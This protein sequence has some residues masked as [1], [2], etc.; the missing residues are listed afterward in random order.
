MS[1]FKADSKTVAQSY[2]NRGYLLHE[3][4]EIFPPR[5]NMVVGFALSPLVSLSFSVDIQCAQTLRAFIR[6]LV[7]QALK[8]SVVCSPSVAYI[9]VVLNVC[10]VVYPSG[11]FRHYGLHAS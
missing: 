8:I 1:S 9:S 4:A 3:L 2:R 7:T 10:I 6:A 11:V 5:D